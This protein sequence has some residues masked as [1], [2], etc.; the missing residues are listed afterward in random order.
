MRRYHQR[1]AEALRRFFAE[2]KSPPS[3]VKFAGQIGV[4]CS[5][6]EAWVSRYP[7]FAKAAG[8]CRKVLLD[9]L[10]DGGLTRQYDPSFV[11]FLLGEQ[12]GPGATPEPD[13][14]F[15]VLIKVV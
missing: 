1:Y 13:K 15:E 4:D 10:I 7:S 6:I 3:L 8:E 12:L 9:R 2:S 11:K 5:D 14:P